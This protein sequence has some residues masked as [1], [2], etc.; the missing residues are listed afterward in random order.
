M[1]KKCLDFPV[2]FNSIILI[3]CRA[4]AAYSD[5]MDPNV[6]HDDKVFEPLGSGLSDFGKVSIIKLE[7]KAVTFTGFLLVR[8][9]YWK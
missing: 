2:S 9:S 4:E 3:Y 8:E 7:V 6:K 1:I 5:K